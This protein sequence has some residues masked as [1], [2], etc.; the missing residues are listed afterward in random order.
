MFDPYG[1]PLEQFDGIGA[2]RDTYKDNSAIDP[3]TKLIDGTELKGST[4]LA[5][6]LSKDPRFKQCI[7]DNMFSYSLGRLLSDAET[8][9]KKKD[10]YR[11]LA[12]VEDRHV[13]SE[14][15]V[16]GRSGSAQEAARSA[17][18]D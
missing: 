16:A 5:D 4:E 13:H 17:C 1:L 18:P 9:E 3:S 15:A 8:D 10:L 11:R 6:A 14:S 2:Y 12:E 7:A